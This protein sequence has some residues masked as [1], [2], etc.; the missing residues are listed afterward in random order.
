[1]NYIAT[2]LD[3]GFLKDSQIWNELVRRYLILTPG[4]VKNNPIVIFDNLDR[5]KPN[6]DDKV[7]LD[8]FDENKGSI[9]TYC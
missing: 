2:Q 1:M 4:I 8:V 5:F 3:D 9:G 6:F 7:Y